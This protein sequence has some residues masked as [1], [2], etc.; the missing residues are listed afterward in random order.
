[1]TDETVRAAYEDFLTAYSGLH[2]RYGKRYYMLSTVLA[3]TPFIS[4]I[5]NDD[6][7]AEDGM[8]LRLFFAKQYK[9]EEEE[10]VLDI[11]SGTCSLLEMMIGLAQRLD[12]MAYGVGD[13]VETSRWFFVILENLGW[14]VF[15]DD[16]MLELSNR[17][18]LGRRIDIL[19]NRQYKPDGRG[20]FFPLKGTKKDQRNVEIWYQA[21]AWMIENSHLHVDSL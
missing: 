18:E 19:M 1:M 16:A 12:G 13:R 15:D 14:E 11:L 20:G 7:R 4:V 2:S 5:G 8:R 6:N 21:N 17:E 9:T 10:R 3:K